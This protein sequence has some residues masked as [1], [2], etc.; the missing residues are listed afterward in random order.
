MTKKEKGIVLFAGFH[1][2]YASAALGLIASI[3]NK[4]KEIPIL[5]YVTEGLL[6]PQ[7]QRIFEGIFKTKVQVL[8]PKHYTTD[9]R[10]TF[11]KAKTRLY[12]LSPFQ[13]TMY[14]DVDMV[15]LPRTTVSQAFALLEGVPFTMP[16]EGYFDIPENV[17]KT[18]GFYQFWSD[19]WDILDKYPQIKEQGRL[20]Q[21]RS[22]MIYFEKS[23]EI[24]KLFTLAKKVYDNPLT[25][26]TS[27]GG[28][29]PD[30]YAFNI[31]SSIMGIHP[32]DDQFYPIYWEFKRAVMR[33][34]PVDQFEIMAKYW[35]Y[36]VGGNET[37]LD[38]KN[39]YNRWIKGSMNTAGMPMLAFNLVDK[40]D[41]AVLNRQKL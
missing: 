31:A 15:W 24:K 20:N 10:V 6:A 5:L 18:T 25:R 4:D 38:Q 12:E 33:K 9:G 26:P 2:S 19:K 7:R 30:E 27:I 21:L 14:L 36:S 23:P 41:I 39:L 37:T 3:R 22:E 1:H 28:A 13:K 17:M 40:K 8:D 11:V 32:H 16:S 35:A 34:P 29:L